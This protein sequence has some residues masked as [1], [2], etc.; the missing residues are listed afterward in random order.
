M[1]LHVATSTW[2]GDYRM[3]LPLSGLLPTAPEHLPDFSRTPDVPVDVSRLLWHERFAAALDALGLCRRWGLLAYAI[4]PAEMAELASLV[5][6]EKWTSANLAKLGERIVT[7]E[8]LT[9][10]R[11]GVRDTLPRRWRET[12][13]S[14]G[15][16]AGQL[17]D[18]AQLLPQYYTAHG[19]EASG[20]PSEA[21]LQSLDLAS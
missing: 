9:L 7:L 14:E 10:T 13:L 17:A 21:R 16:A 4:T 19:W 20:Q 1:A 5:T 15:R 18:L 3:A 6:G 12:A 8:R 11:D 2:P